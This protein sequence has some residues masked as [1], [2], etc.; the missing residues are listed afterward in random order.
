MIHH[1]SPD[2]IRWH[3][4]I[5]GF[6]QDARRCHGVLRLSERLHAAGYNNHVSRVSLRPWNADW[7]EVAENI[8]LV[9]QHHQAEIAVN[10][11]AYSW[12][13]GWGAVQLCRQLAKRG[14]TVHCLVAADGVFRH[15]RLLL[16]WTSLIRRDLTFAPV[17]RIPSNVHTVLPL[18]QTQNRPQGHRIVGDRDFSG[19]IYE[20]REVQSTH[21][22]M[23]DA[24]EF[25][26]L[27]L[28][29]ARRLQRIS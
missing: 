8:W 10:I 17:I 6:T 24:R 23:D 29:A 22:Y 7:D 25:H 21:Q 5:S 1:D 26:A 3:Q 16:R 14:I 28:D 11:Y 19:V 9:G 2:L 15:P 13:V 27:S 12:G 18:H 4:C 20:S